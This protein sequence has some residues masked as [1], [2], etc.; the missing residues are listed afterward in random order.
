MVGFC[1][2]F[3]A[4]ALE[5]HCYSSA[6]GCCGVSD[7]F[8]IL[9]ECAVSESAFVTVNN[10]RLFEQRFVARGVVSH[11]ERAGCGV[12]VIYDES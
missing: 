7:I 2:C 12:T 9:A 1:V 11:E 4:A 10:V 6:Q 8:T 5:M 3:W